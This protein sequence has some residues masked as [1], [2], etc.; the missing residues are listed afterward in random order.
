V[1]LP[2]AM[3]LLG[4]RNWYLPGSLAWL[5]RLQVEGASSAPGARSAVESSR[6]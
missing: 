2:S 3:M 6:G 4:D 1:Q 5:P